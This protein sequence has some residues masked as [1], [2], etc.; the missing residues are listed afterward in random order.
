MTIL[1]VEDDPMILALYEEKLRKEGFRVQTASDGDE[2]L[3]KIT[4]PIDLILLDILLPKR[5]GFEVLKKVKGE[6]AT[7]HIPV[8]V[9]TNLGD[10]QADK[11]RDLAMLLGA[12][13]FLVKSL[14]TPDEIVDRIKSVVSVR[15]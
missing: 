8:L 13:D 3:E 11:N 12:D 15:K 7:K 5:N 9:L 10:E 1:L 6:R 14:H 4:K 2:A